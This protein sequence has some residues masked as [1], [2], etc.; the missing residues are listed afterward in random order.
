MVTDNPKFCSRS[1]AVTTNNRKYPKRYNPNIRRNCKQCGKVLS[2]PD[3]NSTFCNM[4]CCHAFRYQVWKSTVLRSGSFTPV[5]NTGK[6][7]CRHKRLLTE[8]YDWKCQICGR[9]TWL[10]V[11]INLVFDHVDG[12][13][14]NWELDNCRLVCNNCDSTLPTYKGR[15]S[16]KGRSKNR[17]SKRYGG[18][19]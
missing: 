17:Q 11:E 9:K 13:S 4:S 1:C 12:N 16:G 6:K 10:G 7:S 18:V 2:G 19:V 8:L 15:N 3:L 14:D 5:S